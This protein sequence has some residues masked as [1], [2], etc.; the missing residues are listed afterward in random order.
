MCVPDVGTTR[1]SDIP[2]VS[3]EPFQ[4]YVNKVPIVFQNSFRGIP[5]QCQ[6][7]ISEVGG[8]ERGQTVS[9]CPPSPPPKKILIA[10][11]RH[12]GWRQTL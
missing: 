5:E 7:R 10:D 4:D 1:R 12:S 3:S 2:D 6:T 11:E 9:L 8:R